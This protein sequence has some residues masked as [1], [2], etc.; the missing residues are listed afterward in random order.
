MILKPYDQLSAFPFS[1]DIDLMVP[2]PKY[3]V[4][5]CPPYKGMVNP[6]TQVIHFKMAITLMCMPERMVHRALFIKQ[7]LTSTN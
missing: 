6:V 5:K 1:N 2:P 3:F 7:S 4:P